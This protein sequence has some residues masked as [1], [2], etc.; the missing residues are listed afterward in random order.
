MKRRLRSP[1]AF[2]HRDRVRGD[3]MRP[4]TPAAPSAGS[5]GSARR[6]RGLDGP[7]PPRRRR[8]RRPAGTLTAH[9]YQAFTS[10]YP[11]SE[12]GTGGDSMVM[13]LQWDFLAAYDET[14]HPGDAAGRVDRAERRREDLDRQAPGRRHVE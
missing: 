5:A 13:E 9:L 1:L 3:G 7:G 8:R 2:A 6:A 11:W 12:S 10:F 4:C 14:G